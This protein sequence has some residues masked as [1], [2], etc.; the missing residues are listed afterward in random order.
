M[1]PEL[2]KEYA[3][4]VRE[5]L[6][7]AWEVHVDKLAIRLTIRPVQHGSEAD[8]RHPRRDRAHVRHDADQPQL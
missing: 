7:S 6:G 3:R 5:K 2:L 1:T 8:V 4:I